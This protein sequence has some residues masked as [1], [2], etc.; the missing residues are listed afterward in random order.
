MI[1]SN[2][3]HNSG[4]VRIADGV[5]ENQLRSVAGPRRTIQLPLILRDHGVPELTTNVSITI[6]ISK[7]GELRPAW[8]EN[9]STVVLAINETAQPGFVVANLTAK[10]PGH[11]NSPIR[12]L[13]PTRDTSSDVFTERI[14]FWF[15]TE[16]SDSRSVRIYLY[17]PVNAEMKERYVFTVRATVFTIYFPFSYVCI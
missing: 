6:E 16:S 7:G 15:E 10:V 8:D 1:S 14:P 9:L 4:V 13:I 11:P 17:K 3:E 12:Y 2:P 5:D